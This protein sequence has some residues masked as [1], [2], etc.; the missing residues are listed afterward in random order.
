MI[1]YFI[2]AKKLVKIDGLLGSFQVISRRK[3][4]EK[5]SKTETFLF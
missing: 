1:N 2:V 4:L 3:V 5:R